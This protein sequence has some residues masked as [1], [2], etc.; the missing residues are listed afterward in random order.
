MVFKRVLAGKLSWSE[1][2]GKMC[3]VNKVTNRT[4]TLY[5]VT[6]Q[7]NAFPIGVHGLNDEFSSAK[8]PGVFLVSKSRVGWAIEHVAARWGVN[9]GDLVVYRV[10]V[11]RSWLA[12]V[13]WR[14]LRNGVWRCKRHVT[15][16]RIVMMDYRE[17][18]SWL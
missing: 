1:R 8:L 6:P 13:R 7:A 10:S 17:F 14:G 11:R 2:G 12:A 15:P 4:M 9:P 3:T 16:N 5:H 18:V